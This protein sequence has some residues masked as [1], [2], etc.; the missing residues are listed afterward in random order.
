MK[1][2]ILVLILISTF[3]E[4]YAYT[5]VLIAPRADG[6]GCQY[7]VFDDNGNSIGT[8]QDAC[9]PGRVRPNKPRVISVS[10]ASNLGKW[11]LKNDKKQSLSGVTIYHE[12]DIFVKTVLAKKRQVQN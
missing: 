1:K 6:N 10:P 5:Y 2:I 12:N 4:S 7:E 3:I 9:P 11:I 8:C